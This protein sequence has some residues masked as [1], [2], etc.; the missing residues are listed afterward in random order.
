[1]KIVHFFS[2]KVFAG[3]ERHVEELAY[4]QSK[5]H[6]VI[7]VGP[8][9]FKKIFRSTYQILDTNKSRINPLLWLELRQVLM[10]N[11]ADIVHTH[12]AKMTSLIKA[13]ILVSTIHGTK[14]NINPFLKTN[15]IFG[16]SDKSI[17]N[18]PSDKSMVLENWVDQDR[19]TS[20]VKKNP[21]YFLYLGRFEPVK[22]PLR[23]I[24]SWANVDH[25]LLML[26]SGKLYNEA[27]NLIKELNLSDKIR[28]L[29]E[30][31]DVSSFLEKAHALLISSDREG[32][33]KVLYEALYCGVPVLSTD[34]GN[35]KDVLSSRFVCPATD[36]DY[37][38]LIERFCTKEL[39]LSESQREIFETVRNENLLQVQAGKVINIYED[40]LSKASL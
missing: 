4:E 2:S 25:N 22:N 8:K 12:G 32:S 33:P 30:Q 7:V 5:S 38:E 19:F 20:Y 13:D 21:E 15:F 14:T 16:A 40:L 37:V 36:Q 23:L 39:N 10:Q 1:M 18:I 17:E 11:Q 26:G 24:K 35:I 34:V 31:K 29:P 6:E 9:R 27:L 28:I 3:L